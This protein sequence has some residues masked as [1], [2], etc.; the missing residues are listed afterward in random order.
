MHGAT[1]LGEAAEHEFLF[2]A[3]A[4]QSTAFRDGAGDVL[5][6]PPNGI[7]DEFDFLGVVKAASGF[8]EAH[9]AFINELVHIDALTFVKVCD[10]YDEAEVAFDEQVHGFAAAF[11]NFREYNLFLFLGKQRIFG[12]IVQVL[13]IDIPVVMNVCILCHINLVACCFVYIRKSTSICIL[14]CHRLRL[15]SQKL[16]VNFVKENG[17]FVMFLS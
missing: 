12:N 4:D 3:D 17:T 1:L 13:E 9:V 5:A 2:G 7:A 10:V 11:A 6:N 15:C 16:F 14:K 8:N